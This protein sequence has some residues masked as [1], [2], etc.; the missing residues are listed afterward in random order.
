LTHDIGIRFYMRDVREYS[1]ERC[2]W[3][4]R[5][6]APPRRR[7][8]STYD[9]ISAWTPGMTAT[10][11]NQCV[12][13]AS[14]RRVLLFRWNSPNGPW[15]PD[16]AARSLRFSLTEYRCTRHCGSRST[17]VPMS[18]DAVGSN[19]N[20]NFALRRPSRRSPRSLQK[21]AYTCNADP[22]TDLRSARHCR[23]KDPSLPPRYR[24]FSV[25]DASSLARDR[26]IVSRCTFPR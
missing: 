9:S 7:R 12:R 10:S 16:K 25:N 22:V 23:T 17:G 24:S 4:K 14:I 3:R 5:G 18:R 20:S 26:T 8:R 13:I 1:L 11:S 6:R 2:A 19:I 21:C 15:R